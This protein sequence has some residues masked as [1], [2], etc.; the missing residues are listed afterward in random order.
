MT[1]FVLLRHAQGTHDVNY[2]KKESP[3]TDPMYIDAELTQ[4]GKLQTTQ[5]RSKLQDMQFDAIFCSP[6]RRCRSTLI[7]VVPKS[8]DRKVQLDDR[9]IEQPACSNICNTRL[10]KKLY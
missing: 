8:M 6:L 2:F 4:A 3:N 1:T 10:D 7:G 5:T 9:L